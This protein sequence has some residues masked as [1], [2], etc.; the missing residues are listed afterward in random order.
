MPSFNFLGI[1]GASAGTSNSTYLVDQLQIMEN[2]LSADGSLSPG[3]YQLLSGMAQKALLTPGLTA[4]QRSAL[5]VKVSGYQSAA[6]KAQISQNSDITGLNDAHTDDLNTATMLAGNNPT[7]FLQ[8]NAD[9]LAQKLSSLKDS[10]DNATQAGDQTTVSTLTNEYL[11]TL[12]DYNDATNALQDAQTYQTNPNQQPNTDYAAYL[13]TNSKG[14]ITGVQIGRQGSVTG[15][16][17]VK[18]LYGGLPIYG[19]LNSTTNNTKT[20]KLGNQTYTGSATASAI[21][22]NSDGTLNTSAASLLTAPNQGNNYIDMDQNTTAPQ[23]YVPDNGWAQGATSST[24]YQNNGGGKYTKYINADPTKLN[25]PPGGYISLP[26]SLEQALSPAVGTTTDMSAPMPTVPSASSTPTTTSPIAPVDNYPTTPATQSPQGPAGVG[27]QA[28][29][30][31]IARTQAAMPSSPTSIAGIAS[32]AIGK[33]G[34]FLQ[35]LFGNKS[36]P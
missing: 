12:S 33:A 1:P 28:A 23:G 5:Q 19:K 27:S 3:D 7:Q 8:A 14:E 32:Q 17:P 29:Q 15:Y 30:Q 13:T 24:F 36:T 20:F 21:S 2:R 35:G 6:S 31:S 26:S 4:D 16:T 18:A 10:V 22:F 25:I 11:Q 9:S 34:S